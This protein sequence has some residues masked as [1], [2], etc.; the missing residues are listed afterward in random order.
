MAGVCSADSVNNI[1]FHDLDLVIMGG[2]NPVNSGVEDC[3]GFPDIIQ[4][5]ELLKSLRSSL[6]SK[7]TFQEK[8][9]VWEKRPFTDGH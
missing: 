9:R 8:R 6:A 1:K 3:Y 5:K 4:R 2:F 7:N